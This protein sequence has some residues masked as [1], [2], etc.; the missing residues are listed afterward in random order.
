MGRLRHTEDQRLGQRER[1]RERE[2]ER[3]REREREQKSDCVSPRTNIQ[4]ADGRHVEIIKQEKTTRND[5][6]KYSARQA[7]LRSI[8]AM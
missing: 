3:E 1:E 8:L 6:D 2:I 7:N 5:L 4:S